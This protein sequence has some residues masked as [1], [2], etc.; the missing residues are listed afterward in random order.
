MKKNTIETMISYLNGETVDTAALRDELTNELKRLN[1]KADANRAAYDL[2]HAV[3]LSVMSEQP[4]TAKAIYEAAKDELPKEFSPSKVQYALLN[5][6][7]KEVVK[8]ENA[9]G[10]NEYR[11]A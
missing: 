6:W 7:A 5:Y 11:L 10:A 4:M 3:V 8:I 1:A 2:A 9:K